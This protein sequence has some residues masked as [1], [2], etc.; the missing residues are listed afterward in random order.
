MMGLFTRRMRARQQARLRGIGVSSKGAYIIVQRSV[1][2]QASNQTCLPEY[3]L[4]CASCNV[5]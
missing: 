2:N 5:S 1:G 4:D 3:I